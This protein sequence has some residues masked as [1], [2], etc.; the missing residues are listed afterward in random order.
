MVQ[1]MPPARRNRGWIWFFIVLASLALTAMV[2]PI[3]YNLSQQLKPEELA[4]AEKQWREKGPASYQ[5][6]YTVKRGDAEPD[7][8][9]VRVRHGKAVSAQVNDIPQ[10]PNRAHNYTMDRLFDDIQEFLEIQK[11]KDQPQTY[12]RAF[13]D[14]ATGAVRRFIRRVMGTNERLEIEVQSLVPLD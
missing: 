5:L 10:P 2:V 14:P 12:L 9:V 13:F 1:H 7:H 11:R 3:V 4:A 8:F 6:V